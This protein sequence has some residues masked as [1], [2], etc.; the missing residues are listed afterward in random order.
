VTN[1][2]KENTLSKQ[3]SSLY[4][5][6]EDSSDKTQ[7]TEDF[8]DQLSETDST[9]SDIYK[10]LFKDVIKKV[11]DFGGVKL[12]DTDIAIISTLQH[13]ELLEGNTTVVYTHDDHKLPEHYNGLGYMNLIS[14]IFE[15]EIL[16]QDFKKDKDKKPADINLLIIEEPEAHTL[17]KCS[18]SL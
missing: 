9:L 5:K 8:K 3:T 12:N 2:E 18:M 14:M 15:I 10:D 7:A 1:K 4:K 17:P 13:R 6:K 16:V 11:Q